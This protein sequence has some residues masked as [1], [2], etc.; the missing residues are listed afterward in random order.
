MSSILKFLFRLYQWTVSPFLHVIGGPGCGCRYE[1]SCSHYAIQAIET[2]GAGR[3]SWLAMKRIFRCH[4]WGGFGFDPVPEKDSRLAFSFA[5]MRLVKV[6]T[7]FPQSK[8]ENPERG[9][10]PASSTKTKIL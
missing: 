10:Q 3:G 6:H 7:A 5:P 8:I 9:F 1:P 2:H 4:P